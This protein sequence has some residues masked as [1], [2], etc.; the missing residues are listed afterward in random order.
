MP[1]NRIIEIVYKGEST[2]Y[3][4]ST[5]HDDNEE[6]AFVQEL[7]IEAVYHFNE[8]EGD[9]RHVF[10][11]TPEEIQ[12]RFHLFQKK[13]IIFPQNI[14]DKINCIINFIKKKNQKTNMWV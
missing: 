4:Y 5:Y 1:S 3:E 9:P 8:I 12:K 6:I 11:Y 10:E 2:N 14:S 13:F 7:F